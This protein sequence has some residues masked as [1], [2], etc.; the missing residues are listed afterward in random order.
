M[1]G[2]LL[3]AML[4]GMS[5]LIHR[6]HV[7]PRGGVTILAQL[8][9]GSY[10]TGWAYYATNIVV[11]LVLALAANTSFGGLPVLMSLLARNHRLP[12]LFGLRAERPV[13]RYGVICLGVLSGALL[14]S[15]DATTARLIPLYAI[16]VFIGFTISQTGLVHHWRTERPPRWVPRAVLNGTGALMTATAT[17]VFLASKFIEGAWLVVLAVP[18]MMLLFSR[19]ENYYQ[20]VGRELGVGDIPGLPQATTS[21]VIVPVGDITRLTQRALSAAL[22]LGNEVVAVNVRSDAERSA[23]FRARWEQWNPGV[24]LDT[25]V[26]PHRSLVQPIVAYVQQAQALDREIAVLI[27]EVVPRRWRYRILQNQRGLLLATVLRARTDA[28]VCILPYRLASR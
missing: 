26:D 19:I 11:T 4:I 10:G 23:T 3:G 28:V 21:L 2:V 27:P 17:V 25:I 16:G 24:R 22:A 8:A 14:I 20:A 13:F 12:H 7:A 1:L 6:D 18:T 5:V 15:V 9:A